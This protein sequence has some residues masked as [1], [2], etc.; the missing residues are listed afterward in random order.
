VIADV[1]CTRVVNGK[2]RTA[3]NGSPHRCRTDGSARNY[4]RVQFWHYGRR[5]R[6]TAEEIRTS[7]LN[8]P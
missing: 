5:S 3:Q 1:L 2:W 8:Y 7:V 6:T 4:P